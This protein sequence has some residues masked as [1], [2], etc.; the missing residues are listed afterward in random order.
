MNAN[1]YLSLYQ[2][3]TANGYTGTMEELM[4]Q[5][6]AD[7]DPRAVEQNIGMVTAYA[8]AVSKGYTGT[9]DEFAEL[10]ANVGITLQEIE[11]AIDTFVDETV[12][13]AVQQV[14]TTGETQV[15]NVNAAGAEQ[16]RGIAAEGTQQRQNVTT[17]GE[18]QVTAINN[19]GTEQIDAVQA[20]GDQVIASI[21]ADYTEL[22]EEV[23]DVKSAFTELGGIHD[24]II[25]VWTTGKRISEDGSIINSGNSLSISEP[26]TIIDTDTMIAEGVN[27][28]MTIN[29][30][31]IHYYNAEGV[32]VGYSYAYG[33]FSIKE[34]VEELNAKTIRL[35][36]YEN[37]SRPLSAVAVKFDS[38]GK[39]DLDEEQIQEN[40]DA[41]LELSEKVQTGESEQYINILYGHRDSVNNYYLANGALTPN[42]NWCSTADGNFIPVVGGKTYALNYNPPINTKASWWNFTIA[43]YDVDKTYLST[44]TRVS[45]LG[46]LAPDGAAYCRISH[47]NANYGGT[48]TDGFDN[49]FMTEA[50]N[51]VDVHCIDTVKYQLETFPYTTLCQKRWGLFGDSITE[52]NSRATANYHDFIRI[53]TGIITKNYAIGGSGY[54]NRDDNGNAFYQTAYRNRAE[55]SQCDV[56]TIMGGVNDCTRGTFDTIFGTPDDVFEGDDMTA[57]TSNSI[58]ACIKKLLDIII[59]NAPLAKI[60][61]I[62]PL[63]AVTS[64]YTFNPSDDT[65]NMSRLV[66]AIKAI[67][68][69]YGVPFLD[70]YHSSGLRPWDDVMNQAFFLCNSADSPDRLHPNIYG[71]KYIYPQIREFIKT[72]I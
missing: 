51:G 18:Q 17:A 6:Q 41:I 31:S 2:N 40:A 30:P 35:S 50:D 49:V 53:E 58:C 21:P 10:M 45:N 22:A 47:P 57:V 64:G 36:H 27:A 60:A 42:Q 26:I 48:Y 66:E 12:P 52:H 34:K 25:P 16:L 14:M 15:R 20:K 62:S 8:Y 71:Q 28:Y 54:K 19:K 4:E 23:S 9:E 24:T 5:M 59:E 29:M 72:L 39:V 32:H 70:L 13:A 38:S 61:V 11:T 33:T 7:Q 37:A 55:L 43:W 3:L 63:P 1:E 69:D 46:Y 67:C 65:N 56:I 68:N 44:T